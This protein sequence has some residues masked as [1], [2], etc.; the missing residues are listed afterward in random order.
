M[1]VA[2]TNLV[3]YLLIEGERTLEAR[4]VRQRDP[5]WV[6]PPLW[7]SEFLNVLTTAVRASVLQP[8][9]ARDAWRWACELFAHHE[10]EPSGA[11]VLE[12][13]IHYG[14]SAY[15]AQFIVV[16]Q[17]LQVPLVTGDRKILRSCGELAISIQDFALGAA[18][19]S[20]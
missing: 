13:A 6:V 11:E 17:D 18:P 19:E 1:I 7:R 10:H 3:S 14:L 4:R 5:N 2:D 15:D 9:Q 20:E 8:R 12:A 16:A